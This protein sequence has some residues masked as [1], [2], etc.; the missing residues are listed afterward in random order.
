MTNNRSSLQKS[1]D[2]GEAGDAWSHLRQ[3]HV[4]QVQQSQTQIDWGFVIQLQ[5][6]DLKATLP[7]VPI[8]SFLFFGSLV[9]DLVLK[10]ELQPLIDLL[11][12]SCGAF[13]NAAK[14]AKPTRSSKKKSA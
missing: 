9:F 2:D 11:V 5:W 12:E 4:F 3:K 13:D 14:P 8:K 7:T 10:A 1:I 6:I